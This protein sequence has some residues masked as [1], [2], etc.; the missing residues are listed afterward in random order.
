MFSNKLSLVDIH[1]KEWLM[2]MSSLYAALGTRGSNKSKQEGPKE[3]DA[4]KVH[5]KFQISL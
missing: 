3:M 4:T 2:F 5:H 1:Y